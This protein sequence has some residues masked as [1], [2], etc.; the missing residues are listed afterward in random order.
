MWPQK[1]SRQPV[2]HVT[3]QRYQRLKA[4]RSLDWAG[5]KGFINILRPL[6]VPL[7]P[8]ERGF[9]HVK[10]VLTTGYGVLQ[11]AVSRTDAHYPTAHGLCHVELSVA[12]GQ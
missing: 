8:T 3:L 1:A 10:Q 6:T 12:R 11:Q 7:K 9:S 4:V 5:D 2:A